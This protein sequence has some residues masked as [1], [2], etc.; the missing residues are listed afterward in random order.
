MHQPC[1]LY[2]A[3]A[4][5]E[6]GGRLSVEPYTAAEQ[7]AT[8]EQVSQLLSVCDIFSPNEIEMESMVGAGAQGRMLALGGLGGADA[9]GSIGKLRQVGGPASFAT[10]LR[11][12]LMI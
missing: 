2:V 10:R 9:G 11:Y 6:S 3:Q 12:D 5:H 4:A 8:P 7:P 1:G